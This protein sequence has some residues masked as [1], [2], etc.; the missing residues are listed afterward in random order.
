MLVDI[1]KTSRSILLQK[2]PSFVY[3]A[4]EL[5]GPPV[6]IYH[7]IDPASFERDLKYLTDNGYLFL[8]DVCLQAII[9]GDYPFTGREVALT[10]D[11]GYDDLLQVATPLLRSYGA[12]ATAFIVPGLIGYPGYLNW[13]D[14]Y[15]L[16]LSGVISIGAH[17][18]RHAKIFVSDILEQFYVPDDAVE[19]II[20][21]CNGCD[22]LL[23][24]DGRYGRPLYRT[25]SRLGDRP[26]YLE[27]EQ[28][29]A[30]CVE[31]TAEITSLPGS[32]AWMRELYSLC[33]LYKNRYGGGR[34]ETSQEQESAVHEELA[35]AKEVLETKLKHRIISLRLPW[36][37]GGELVRRLCRPAGYDL[38]F[39]GYIDGNK[40]NAPGTDPYAICRLSGDFVRTLPGRE[41]VG[42]ASVLAGKIGRRLKS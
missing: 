21:R 10:F 38:C 33:R 3:G 42:L 25:S 20:V 1:L 31:R 39:A 37:E 29:T 34:L 7:R 15:R 9:Q 19:E 35:Y 30:L 16:S 6:F 14:L 27:D 23:S 5:Y 12:V 2:L 11:D 36:N 22:T 13:E 40:S 41:R 8:N 26:R 18:Y 17:S 24:V 4:P 32:E 28:L